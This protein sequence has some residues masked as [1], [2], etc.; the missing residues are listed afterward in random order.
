MFENLKAKVVE[1]EIALANR[2]AAGKTVSQDRIEM[3]VIHPFRMI[4][5]WT[6]I[7]MEENN[8]AELIAI[9]DY[10][11]DVI[12]RH[13]IAIAEDVQGAIK[14]HLRDHSVRTA[15][16]VLWCAGFSQ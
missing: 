7:E 16:H 11:I 12:N 14:W 6:Y 1:A 4:S 13:N 3:F 5:K 15:D 2:K 8:D 9:C 10:F